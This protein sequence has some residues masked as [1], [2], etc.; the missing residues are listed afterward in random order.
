LL[1][2]PGVIDVSSF[3][4]LVEAVRSERGCAP[5][6]RCQ[7]LSLIDV[8]NAL[9]EQQRQHRAAATSRKDRT[10]ISSGAKA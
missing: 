8:F 6:G 2:V 10:S 1:G 3:G 4:G 7:D 5:L 9:A